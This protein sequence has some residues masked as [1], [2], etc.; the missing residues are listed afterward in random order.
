MLKGLFNFYHYSPKQRR[1]LKEVASIMEEDLAHLGYI[2]QIFQRED[3]L[4]IDVSHELEAAVLKLCAL[5]V[6]PTRGGS[7]ADFNRLYKPTERM[8]GDVTLQGPCPSINFAEDPLL[9]DLIDGINNYIDKRFHN[10]Y[11]PPLAC[12]EAFDIGRWPSNREDLLLHGDDDVTTVFMHFASLFTE[13][14]IAI[15]KEQFTDLKARVRDIGGNSMYRVY[16]HLLTIKPSN[17]NIIL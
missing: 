7:M 8:F 17:L 2:K 15:G 10:F 16:Q 13:D 12:F 11:E 14:E 9:H 1:D 4:V 5:K 6:D 3:L